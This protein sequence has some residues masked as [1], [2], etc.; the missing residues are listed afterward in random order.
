MS[1]SR[2]SYL[3]VSSLSLKPH[4]S[5]YININFDSVR[6]HVLIIIFFPKIQR[7]NKI[8]YCRKFFL[9]TN[10]EMIRL[11]NALDNKVQS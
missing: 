2:P 9:A 6:N 10:Y 5:H 11:C 4:N 7:F 1:R 3:I 8:N